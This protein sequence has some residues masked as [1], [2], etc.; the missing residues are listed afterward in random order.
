[1]A[2]IV[3]ALNLTDA[4]KAKAQPILD[5]VDPQLQAIRQDAA[6]KSKTVV[7]TT[8][9]QLKPVLTTDQQQKLDQIQQRLNAPPAASS[10]PQ[11][12]PSPSATSPAATPAP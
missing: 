10:V 9:D 12:K 1:M 4:Q 11:A 3:S 6:S 5:K 8:I 7:L 2:R